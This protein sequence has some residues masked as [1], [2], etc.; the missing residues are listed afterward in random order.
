MKGRPWGLEQAR[1]SRSLCDTHGHVFTTGVCGLRPWAGGLPSNKAQ[2]AHPWHTPN[3]NQGHQMWH[4]LPF[5]PQSLYRQWSNCPQ[6][7][8]SCEGGTGH[9]V[10]CH[11]PNENLLPSVPKSVGDV[12]GLLTGKVR[13]QTALTQ[14]CP[15]PR[16]TF[17]GLEQTALIIMQQYLE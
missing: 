15:D 11:R 4:L 1:T 10:S 6:N 16:C 14:A 3:R 13:T 12:S 5:L 7:L 9:K 8:L 17:T 2:M